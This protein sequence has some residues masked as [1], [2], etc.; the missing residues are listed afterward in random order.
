LNLRSCNLYLISFLLYLIK[1][2][3][4]VSDK[5]FSLSKLVV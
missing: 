4:I 1:L 3:A 2:P 5:R